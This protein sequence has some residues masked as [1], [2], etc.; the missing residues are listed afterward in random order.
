[1]Q[2]QVEHVLNIVS[3]SPEQ[4]LTVHGVRMAGKA[5]VVELCDLRQ[6]LRPGQLHVAPLHDIE[7]L[8]PL[9]KIDSKL[10]KDIGSQIWYSVAQALKYFASEETGFCQLNPDHIYI[11]TL[12]T[13]IYITDWTDASEHNHHCPSADG[14]SISMEK[15]YLAQLAIF[16]HFIE[17]G[18]NLH[19]KLQDVGQATW[20]NKHLKNAVE[21]LEVDQ[22]I[23]NSLL[24]ASNLNES[25]YTDINAL[26]DDLKVHFYYPDPQ[27]VLPFLAGMWMSF[28]ATV[29]LTFT[30][31][32]LYYG[33]TLI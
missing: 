4:E 2:A 27:G 33:I 20:R 26:I 6:V 24:R 31:L 1:M 15:V 13:N 32:V 9:S 5:L 19:E 17:S 3:H 7:S 10:R 23:K 14:S 11:N 28:S 30:V 29:S 16:Y 8:T 12:S 25:I 21:A 22:Q 18:E